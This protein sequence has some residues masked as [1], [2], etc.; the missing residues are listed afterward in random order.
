MERDHEAQRR[1][2]QY[3]ALEATSVDLDD[4]GTSTR[5]WHTYAQRDGAWQPNDTSPD[6]S[7][8]W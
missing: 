7:V 3:R 1:E 8:A 4:E 2:N 5:S 6:Y